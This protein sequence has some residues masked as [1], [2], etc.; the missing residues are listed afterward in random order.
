MCYNQLTYRLDGEEGANMLEMKACY[1]CDNAETNPELNEEN[2]LSYFSVGEWTKGFRIMIRS[3]DRKPIK[4]LFEQWAEK[5][6]WQ[7]IA[8]YQPNYCPNCGRKLSMKGE[9]NRHGTEE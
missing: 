2:D 8:Y 6:N 9:R 4:I 5:T 1:M 3:G 7:T